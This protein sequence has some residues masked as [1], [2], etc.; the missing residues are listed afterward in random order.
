MTVSKK[1]R[2]EIT[3]SGVG[4]EAHE[5]DYCPIAENGICRL[6]NVICKYGLTEGEPPY[7]CPINRGLTLKFKLV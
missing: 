2:I 7:I 3:K 5:Y 4:E 1:I 6:E